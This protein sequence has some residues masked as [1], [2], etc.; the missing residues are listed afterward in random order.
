[1]EVGGVPLL[2]KLHP[3]A[4]K[5]VIPFTREFLFPLFLTKLI[6]PRDGRETLMQSYSQSSTT[7]ERT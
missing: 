3:L 7:T 5:I 2:L 4:F 1:M 6:F